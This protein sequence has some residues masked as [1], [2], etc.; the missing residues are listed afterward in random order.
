MRVGERV[1]PTTTLATGPLGKNAS[2]RAMNILVRVRSAGR[3][4]RAMKV[5]TIDDHGLIREAMRGVLLDAHGGAE[6]PVVLE[7][8]NCQRAMELLAENGDLD[9]V[10]LD[11]SLPDRD[12]LDMLADVRDLYPSVSVV[13]L[14]ARQDPATI[15]AVLQHGAHGFIPKS[16]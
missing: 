1:S 2:C 6:P 12:G 9:L 14:S 4:E 3:L 10:L 13:I 11:L 8:A 5:L 16:A 7:A 15:R